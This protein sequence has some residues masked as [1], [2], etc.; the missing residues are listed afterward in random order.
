MKS[1]LSITIA[2]LVLS[3]APLAAQAPFQEFFKFEG[4]RPNDPTISVNT[5][6]GSF[7]G[8]SSPYL[9]GLAPL[10]TPSN[11]LDNLLIWCVDETHDAFIGQ[12]Y[13]AWIT[14]L[15]GTDFSKTRQ[16]TTATTKNNYVWAAYLASQMSLDWSSAANRGRDVALQDAMWALLDEGVGASTREA[17]FRNSSLALSLGIPPASNGTFDFDTS[18][19]PGGFDTSP[20]FLISCDPNGKPTCGRGYGQEFLVELPDGTG[21]GTSVT[22]EPTTL[23]LMGTGLAAVMGMGFRRRKKRI[24]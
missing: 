2:A 1:R 10:A 23:S 22:P 20:W 3:A 13:E 15:A 5:G 8:Y 24:A 21:T 4:L 19:L 9:G 6:S 11:Y 17:N 16:G 7:L 14:P 18:G 12:N